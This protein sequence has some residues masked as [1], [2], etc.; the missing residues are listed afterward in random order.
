MKK[1]QGKDTPGKSEE[2]RGDR[3][4]W[5]GRRVKVLEDEGYEREGFVTTWHK[6]P[7]KVFENRGEN[8]WLTLKKKKTLCLL[9]WEQAERPY[10]ESPGRNYCY[11]QGTGCWWLGPGSKWEQWSVVGFS[12]NFE[13]RADKTWQWTAYE[14]REQGESQI[15]PNFLT[16]VAR[17]MDLLLSDT[18]KAAG[19]P[20]WKEI[21][22]VWVWT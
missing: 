20:V 10:A 22:R 4:G 6:K 1:S 11:D 5:R 7:R 14:V 13:S 21:L 12:I 9:R 3:C 17:R 15:T 19:G 16:Q 18:Q 2:Q 8:F